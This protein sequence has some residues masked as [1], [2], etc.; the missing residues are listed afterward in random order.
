MTPS[1]QAARQSVAQAL[2]CDQAAVVWG[3]PA[4]GRAPLMY[5]AAPWAYI[6]I[7][8]SA[9]Q[10]RLFAEAFSS[11]AGPRSRWVLDSLQRE[12]PLTPV[13]ADW[14]SL[15]AMLGRVRNPTC[16]DLIRWAVAVVPLR[17]GPE[18]WQ[19]SS[20]LWATAAW[21]KWRDVVLI[22]R[23]DGLFQLRA[24]AWGALGA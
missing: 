24:S 17:Q 20:T 3:S 16:R 15:A 5:I 14:I 23:A 22:Q 10:A 18:T 13:G 21:T 19:I 6:V 2:G 7:G 1:I 11:G 8:H 12:Y 9:A 4:P